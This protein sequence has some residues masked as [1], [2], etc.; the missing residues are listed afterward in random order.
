MSAS[1]D[2]ELDRAVLDAY[3]VP[4]AP[5][6]IEDRLWQR[7]HA[8]RP[9]RS[10]RWKLGAGA[11]AVGAVGAAASVAW[12]VTA[13]SP[14]VARSGTVR[15]AERTTLSI[16]KATLVA[17]PGTALTWTSSDR[18]V[19]VEQRGGNVFYRVEP[20]REF[21]VVTD[22]GELSVLGTCFRVEVSSM[23]LP[24]QGLV[25]GAIGAAVTAGVFVAVF[26]GKVSLANQHGRVEIPAGQSAQ[27]AS[28]GDANAG[29]PAMTST[30]VVRLAP[31][32]QPAEHGEPVANG[33]AAAAATAPTVAAA[34]TGD[35]DS[36][37]V[38]EVR[39]PLWAAAQ[40]QEMKE[41]LQKYIGISPDS[42]ELDCR[43]RCCRVR[44]PRSLY[45]KH[46]RELQSSV[47]LG[48]GHDEMSTIHGDEARQGMVVA[49]VCF[50]RTDTPRGPDRG[51]EREALLSTIRA[52]LA[53]CARGLAHEVAISVELTLDES[54]AITKAE[55]RSVP[56]SED[57]AEC[58]ERAVVGAAAFA[59]A[60][61]VSWLPVNVT[62]PL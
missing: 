26:E 42:I 6:G 56:A 46:A 33:A 60:S 47:G 44:M 16:G 38:R 12:F 40:E 18:G 34:V 15:T 21:V 50:E 11:A 39:D 62:L 51:A 49:N 41:R 24:R 53:S 35:G 8:A 19:R 9:R 57:A 58:V 52:E 5:A 36:T 14:A 7:M 22:A 17:E 13:G 23:K 31:G 37:P 43:T 25:G 10:R 2:R 54:G 30:D 45:D 20:G 55:T 32:A 27:I 48:G 61:A 28:G 59:P 1:D 3:E 29:P 4:A